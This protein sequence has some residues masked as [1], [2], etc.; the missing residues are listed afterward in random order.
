MPAQELNFLEQLLEKVEKKKIS[1][2][3]RL[4]YMG[5]ILSLALIFSYVEALIP[6]PFAVPGMKL[7]LPN[8]VIVVV[9][10]L[11][12]PVPALC[13]NILRV[14]I[15]GILFTNVYSL[16]FSLFGAAFSFATMVL[17]QKV[18]HGSPVVTSVFGGLFHNTGQLA[19]AAIAVSTFQ[20]AYYLP[21]LLLAGFITGLIIGILARLIIPRLKILLFKGE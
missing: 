15:V 17:V 8:I 5:I 10:Y 6:L 1:P 16:L 19:A 4:A 14:V 7:G 20:I 12:G 9:L 21:V 18:F 2:A 3:I 13:I 11:F